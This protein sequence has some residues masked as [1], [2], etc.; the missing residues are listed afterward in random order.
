MVFGGGRGRSA[1]TGSLFFADC[2]RRTPW[3]AAMLFHMQNSP[4]GLMKPA[5]TYTHAKVFTSRPDSH[6]L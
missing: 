4:I 2:D 6:T 3:W 1:Q 5:K